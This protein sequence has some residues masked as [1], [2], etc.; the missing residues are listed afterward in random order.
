MGGD[1]GEERVGI[2]RATWVDDVGEFLCCVAFF[3]G[4][5]RGRDR[6]MDGAQRG[7]EGAGLGI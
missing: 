3:Y 7:V 6:R 4:N 5:P 1:F 2:V